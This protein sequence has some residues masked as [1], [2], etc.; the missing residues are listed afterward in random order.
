MAELVSGSFKNGEIMKKM[1][2]MVDLMT[3]APFTIEV[4]SSLA[5]ARVI[6]ASHHIR[7]LPVMSMG[8][9]MGLLTDRDLKFALAVGGGAANAGEVK[10]ED[11]CL[12]EP[13]TV[14]YSARLD[15]VLRSMGDQHIGSAL[16]MRSGRLVGIFTLGDAAKKLCELLPEIFPDA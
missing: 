7:H 4:G 3:P 2:T 16:V 11:A 13:Y 8:R 5:Q 10:V 9:L 15:H 14:E 12:D 1:P 6:M